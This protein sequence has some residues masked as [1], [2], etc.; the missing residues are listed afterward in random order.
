MVLSDKLNLGPRKEA[1]AEVGRR[2]SR[3]GSGI[4]TIDAMGGRKKHKVRLGG[5]WNL[6]RNRAKGKV[7]LGLK[8]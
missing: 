1:P 3:E 5:T 6:F 4:G 7:P 2:L 8:V